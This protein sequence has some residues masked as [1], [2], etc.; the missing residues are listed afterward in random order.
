MVDI[1]IAMDDIRVKVVFACRFRTQPDGYGSTIEP[2]N[3]AALWFTIVFQIIW[4][5]QVKTKMLFD[6]PRVKYKK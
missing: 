3:I 6:F 2:Q 4:N 1:N 5:P